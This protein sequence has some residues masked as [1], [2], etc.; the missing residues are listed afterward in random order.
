[1]HPSSSQAIRVLSP[2]PSMPIFRMVNLKEFFGEKWGK[3]WTTKSVKIF[4]VCK[5]S[6]SCVITYK[7]S[8]IARFVLL[9]AFILRLT[10]KLIIHL[11]TPPF[12]CF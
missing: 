3:N 5:E 4:L 6:K 10:E 8:S 2:L 1:M 9:N 7:V 12:D 11:Y